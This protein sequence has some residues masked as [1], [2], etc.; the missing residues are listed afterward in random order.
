M[1]MDNQNMDPIGLLPKV[2][3]GEATREEGRLVED[4]LSAN[5]ANRAEY[6]AFARLWNLTSAASDTGE[7]DINLEWQKIESEI[8]PKSARTIILKRFLQIAA[9]VIL[10]S[11]LAFIGLQIAG[12]KSEKAPSNELSS[13]MLPDST[14]IFLNAGSKITYKK[15]F[16]ISHRNLYLKGEAYFEVR[17]NRALPFII[18]TG[19]ACV[20][21]TGTKFNIKAYRHLKDIKVT[22]TEG[23]VVLF[24]AH[25]PGRA[26]TLRAGETGS[27]SRTDQ[28]VKKQTTENLNDLAWKTRVMDFKN[29][30]LF[31]VADILMNTYHKH[32]EIDPALQNCS[33]TVRFENQE[34]EAVLA[35]LRS[36]LGLN[37]ETRGKRIVI[38]GK[39]C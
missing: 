10:I 29:T 35:V 26:I 21:V 38:S 13:A 11:G 16:G 37:M 27:Y 17:K 7:I 9:I 5:P 19:G 25:Q 18:S 8:S 2:F 24:D 39:G 30:S 23:N 34:L 14:R 22:V 33:V 6:D 36:T 3:A 1:D 31:E 28:T 12:G 32:I 4:W 15:G 20:R